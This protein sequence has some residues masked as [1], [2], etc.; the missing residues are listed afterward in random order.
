MPGVKGRQ[1]Y[2][3]SFE[4]LRGGKGLGTQT[5]KSG[6]NQFL[7]LKLVSFCSETVP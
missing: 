3:D 5:I 7:Y 4:T 1:W 2:E 6:L